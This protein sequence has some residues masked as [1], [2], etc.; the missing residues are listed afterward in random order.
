MEQGHAHD[1]FGTPEEMLE[2][3]GWV[4]ALARALVRDAATADDIAQETWLAALRR[5]ASTYI[6]TKTTIA[7][8][9]RIHFRLLAGSPNSTVPSTTS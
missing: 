2:H 1:R 6:G 8:D 7:V 9:A 4:R 3:S 5:A